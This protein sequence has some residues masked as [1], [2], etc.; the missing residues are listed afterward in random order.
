MMKLKALLIDPDQQSR[1][2]LAS[3]ISKLDS[4]ELIGQYENGISCF[5]AH[6]FRKADLLLL[7]VDLPE[8]SGIQFVRTIGQYGIEK[9]F[10]SSTADYALQG[11]ELNIIDYLLKPIVFARFEKAMQKAAQFISLKKNEGSPGKSNSLHQAGSII[12]NRYLF[13]KADYKIIKLDIQQIQYIEGFEEYVR[14]HL[15]N[16]RPLI[17]LQ[18]LK[19]LMEALPE[20]QFVRV[21]RSYIINIAHLDYVHQKEVAVGGKELKIGKKYHTAFYAFLQQQGLF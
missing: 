11:Y 2:K 1:N 7:E 9:I 15:A 6:D 20:A 13:V 17:V 19:R 16:T 21:H 4:F 18:S 8:V 14:I 5:D 12:P 3:Y 10:V